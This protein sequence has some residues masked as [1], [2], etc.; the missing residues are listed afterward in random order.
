MYC[1]RTTSVW[2]GASQCVYAEAVAL[3]HLPGE[4]KGGEE[5]A[6]WG[7][8]PAGTQAGL[9]LW[10]RYSLGGGAAVQRG[11]G[12]ASRRLG[13]AG[14][15]ASPRPCLSCCF[16]LSQCLAATLPA[17]N[18]RAETPL[19]TGGSVWSFSSSGPSLSPLSFTVPSP[20]SVPPMCSL[21]TLVTN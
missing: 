3:I 7:R 19:L 2:R 13:G 12:E 4:G 5:V 17:S 9:L 16:S 6:S 1:L 14:V 18:R 21:C 11:R 20:L 15:L 10:G 8:V